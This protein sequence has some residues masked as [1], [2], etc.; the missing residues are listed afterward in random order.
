MVWR[1]CLAAMLLTRIPRLVLHL[2]ELYPD[3]DDPEITDRIDALLLA[4]PDENLPTPDIGQPDLQ[5]GEGFAS[6]QS[7]LQEQFK[8]EGTNKGEIRRA[9]AACMLVDIKKPLVAALRRAAV[10]LDEFTALGRQGLTDFILDL[11]SRVALLELMW[12]QHA[13]LQTKWQANDLNDLVYLSAAIG[14]CD[15][16]VTERRWAAMLTQIDVRSRTGTIVLG[17]LAELTAALEAP[18]PS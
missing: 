6:A 2:R 5:F 7:T 14:Y 12:R 4:G 10:T 1:T 3:L 15:I 8:K 16:V 17:K 11:P 18:A 13:D 9:V